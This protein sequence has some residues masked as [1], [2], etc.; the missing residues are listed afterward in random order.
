M[1]TDWS[2]ATAVTAG[3]ELAARHAEAE[4]ISVLTAVATGTTRPAI[5]VVSDPNTDTL[6]ADWLRAKC[7]TL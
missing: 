7:V 4:A 2:G 1:D 3:V 5:G 6:K